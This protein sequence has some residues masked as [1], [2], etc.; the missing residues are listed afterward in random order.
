MAE[1]S[2]PRGM[3]RTVGQDQGR[4]RVT[5]PS[6]IP[7][8]QFSTGMGKALKDFSFEM[9]SASSHVE[10]QLDQQAQAEGTVE[11]ATAGA[12]GSFEVVDYTTIRGRAYNEAGIKTFVN[13][14]ETRSI[15]AMDGF[16]RQYASDPA[17]LQSAADSYFA[18]V[19]DE[20]DQVC[21]YKN[22]DKA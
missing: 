10:D 12:T 21:Q 17:G 3:V 5:P 8:I 22:D 2:T 15:L 9:F 19:A 18:G 13:T 7:R 4:V 1:T 14:L 16:R 6:S 20:I 11:G